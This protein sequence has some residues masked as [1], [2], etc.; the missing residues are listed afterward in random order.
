MMNY[1]QMWRTLELA[2]E[3]RAPTAYKEMKCQRQLATYLDSL[4]GEAM[5]SISTVTDQIPD[6]LMGINDPMKRVQHAEMVRKTAEEVALSQAIEAMP[7]EATEDEPAEPM[8]LY[9]LTGDYLDEY[10]K[11]VGL[12]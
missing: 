7:L 1:Q 2:L 5:D 12:R 11:K 3:D 10:L 6:N 9:D 8:S 4:T